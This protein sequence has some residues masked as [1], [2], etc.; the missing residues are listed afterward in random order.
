[1]SQITDN[2][3]SYLHCISCMHVYNVHQMTVIRMEAFAISDTLINDGSAGT[4]DLAFVDADKIG[5]DTYYE[6]LLK[7]VRPGGLI[8]FDNVSMAICC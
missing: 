4:F 2:G 5:Y 8:I 1:M 7:L 3:F 6:L